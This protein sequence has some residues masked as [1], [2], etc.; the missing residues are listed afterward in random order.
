MLKK[1]GFEMKNI[2][3]LTLFT[4]C[5]SFA[6]AENV[7][8]ENTER[9]SE[10]F[11]YKGQAKET[12]KL[13]WDKMGTLY[14]T[15]NR[16]S[17][18]TRPI[19]YE[20]YE[21]NNETRYRQECRTE[22]G[23]NDCQTVYDN[24]CRDVP[25]SRQE[26]SNGPSTQSC[27]TSPSSEN[28]HDI[29]SRE[30]CRMVNGERR[31]TTI[32][33]RRR[34]NTVPG[35]TTCRTIPGSRSCRTVSYTER[36]CENV[37]RQQCDWVS[38]REV[39]DDIPYQEEVCGNVTRY[40]YEEYACQEAYQVPYQAVVASFES[41]STIL[42]SGESQQDIEF[43][44]TLNDK[45]E[46]E[47]SLVGDADDTDFV[48]VKSKLIEVVEQEETTTKT[49]QMFSFELQ[50]RA[51]FITSVKNSFSNISLRKSTQALKFTVEKNIL[52]DDFKI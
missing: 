12:I 3:L 46:S 5:F 10:S 41:N 26:C 25:R 47:I 23:Y 27:S 34:C 17:T 28:C 22:P 43:N 19:P 24:V 32:P 13:K 2:I 11:L 35:R 38:S 49:E 16:D 21:C 20:V 45:G 29:P 9:P 39:C 14:R 37:S 42:F 40:N 15:E 1:Q 52:K 4:T 30:R 7:V 33:G 6:F 44:I 18:C 36:E 50:S 8:S 48:F 31:C 51:D